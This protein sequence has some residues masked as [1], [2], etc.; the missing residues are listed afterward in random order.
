MDRNVP[1]K[2]ARMELFLNHIINTIGHISYFSPRNILSIIAF[3]MENQNFRIEFE[4]IESKIISQH[5]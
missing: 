2:E 4:N 5:F 3:K 1:L